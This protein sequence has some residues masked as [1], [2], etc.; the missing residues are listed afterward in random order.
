MSK[1]TVDDLKRWA[2]RHFREMLRSQRLTEQFQRW[3]DGELGRDY[4]FNI[5]M[6]L[7]DDTANFFEDQDNRKK[8]KAERLAD[9]PEHVAQ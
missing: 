4:L 9:E 2:L 6:R 7:N 8:L 5:E 3:A 1:P